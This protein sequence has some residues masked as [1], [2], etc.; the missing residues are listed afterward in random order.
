V[1]G[2]IYAKLLVGLTEQLVISC[3]IQQ[4]D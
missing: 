3:A 2:V 4:I 1:S